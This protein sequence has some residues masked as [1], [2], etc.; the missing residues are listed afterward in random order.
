MF[1]DCLCRALT[2]Q[3]EW[4]RAFPY[5]C[6]SQTRQHAMNHHLATKTGRNKKHGRMC[7]QGMIRIQWHRFML[8][9]WTFIAR[10]FTAWT[11]PVVLHTTDTADL[12]LGHIPAPCCDG[13]PADYFGFHCGCIC[14]I[15]YDIVWSSFACD[16]SLFSLLFSCRFDMIWYDVMWCK[17][18]GGDTLARSDVI[19]WFPPYNNNNVDLQLLYDTST[20]RM[21]MMETSRE[22]NVRWWG[23][24]ERDSAW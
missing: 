10:I 2:H 14:L 22:E 23:R 3:M 5:D 11:S 13:V 9:Q 6:R 19:L 18:Y 8:T 24:E 17:C 4:M 12:V 21:M 7:L 20:I 15:W 16:I 1:I